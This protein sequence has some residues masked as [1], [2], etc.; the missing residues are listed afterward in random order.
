M[1]V[2]SMASGPIQL[3]ATRYLALGSFQRTESSGKPPC[4]QGG[5]SVSGKGEGT[6]FSLSLK[7]TWLS[8]TQT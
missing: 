3:S 2:S 7:E 5:T 8:L 4:W 1:W 6:W